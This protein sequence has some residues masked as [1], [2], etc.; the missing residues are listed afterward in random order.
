MRS[1]A[2]RYLTLAK[3]T[4]DPQERKDFFDYAALYAQMSARPVN[5]DDP[6]AAEDKEQGR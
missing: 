1:M 5:G 4:P 6:T 2:E 3:T